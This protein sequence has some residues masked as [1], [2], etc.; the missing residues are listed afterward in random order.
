MVRKIRSVKH[1]LRTKQKGSR[2]AEKGLKIAKEIVVDI[3]FSSIF[4]AVFRL[5]NKVTDYVDSNDHI[6][7]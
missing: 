5:E 1:F 7:K 6:S 3:F 4:L 2:G